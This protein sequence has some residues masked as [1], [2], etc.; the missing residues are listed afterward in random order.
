MSIKKQ[1]GLA[2]YWDNVY[3]KPEKE[4]T[5]HE[6]VP[7]T[8]I[9][10]IEKAALPKNAP[11]IDVGGGDGT[12]ARHLL[13][14]GYENITVLDI[15]ARA[16]EIGQKRL[17][18]MAS[19]V[20]W[21]HSNVLDFE[22]HGAYALWHDRATFHFLV[23]KEEQLGYMRSAWNSLHPAGTL[24]LSTFSEKGPAQCS[25]LPVQRY[26]ETSLASLLKSLFKKNNFIT[27]QHITPI[28]TL[29]E[30]LYGRF[31]KI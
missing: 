25:G 29:Q 5:W 10:L 24:I 6:P 21:V 16:I 30:F 27:R 18:D 15:S 7:V 26:S 1:N 2:Q 20:R 13:V 3:R 28:H 12:L 8:S 22:A 11:I 19:R 23:Q 14:L 9:S 4:L 31:M 17:G